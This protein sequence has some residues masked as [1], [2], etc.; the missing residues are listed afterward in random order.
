MRFMPE[1]MDVWNQEEGRARQ[2]EVDSLLLHSLL[3]S[4][5]TISLVT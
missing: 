2:W 1:Y 5:F 4:S 3:K